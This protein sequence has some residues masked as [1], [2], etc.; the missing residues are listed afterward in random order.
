MQALIEHVESGAGLENE[1][2]RAAAAALLDD[3]EAIE[4]KV[5]FLKA[6]HRRG[7]TPEEIASFVEAFLEHAVIPPL[8]ADGVQGPMIDVCGTG[9]DKLDFFN[10]STT[11]M[12][13]LAAG[14]LTVVKHGNRG[15]TS[16]SGGADVLE[17]LGVRIDLG[18]EAFAETVLAHGV[19][20]LFAPLYHPAFKAVAPVRKILAKQGEKTVF[21]LLGPLLNPM[22]PA[23]QL[24]GVFDET[25]PPVY[26]DILGKLGRQEAWAVH[27]K[28][29]DGRGVDELSTMGPTTIHRCR[30]GRPNDS[31]TI[32]P[33][34]LG[35][36][37]ARVEDLQG[38]EAAVNASILEGVLSGELKDAK[39]D[40][41]LV[42]AAAGLVITG[43]VPDLSAG[44]ARA[45]ELIDSGAALAKLRALQG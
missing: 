32:T 33:E 34:E 37:P 28:I 1:Q 29:G 7:E 42:N 12:F 9:G 21:N 30:A 20:F 13:V 3:S 15:I 17:A 5:A 43:K 44:V 26:A 14:G 35:L 36:A 16:K 45:A 22:S 39:R 23:H 24:I 6:L 11:S 18:P 25:L 10:I 41:T 4:G 8:T 2:V 27:G 40:I 38:G 19:G 31:W